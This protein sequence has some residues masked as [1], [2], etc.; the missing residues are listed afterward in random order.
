[1]NMKGYRNSFLEHLDSDEAAEFNRDLIRVDIFLNSYYRNLCR[2]MIENECQYFIKTVTINVPAN[3]DSYILPDD[4]VSL[5]LLSQTGQTNVKS[6]VYLNKDELLEK[7]S[8]DSTGILGNYL[9]NYSIIGNIIYF[10]PNTS[11]EMNLKMIYQ[12]VPDLP[13]GNDDGIVLF[14]AGYE[15]IPI[16]YALVACSFKLRENVDALS[17][18]QNDKTEMM[19]SLK[20]SRTTFQQTR[21]ERM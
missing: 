18:F 5:M 12:Y 14:P 7:I 8:C 17:L 13:V 16:R 10:Y 20:R 3:S 21:A 2:T 19:F 9:L 1:M 11:A 6:L 4:F 15:N